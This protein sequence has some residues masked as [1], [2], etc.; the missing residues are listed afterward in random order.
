MTG[1]LDRVKSSTASALRLLPVAGDPGYPSPG[2]IAAGL[3]R[4]WRHHLG[5]M[6]RLT[7]ASA[8]MMALDP[9]TAEE[10]AESTLC[11]LRAGEPIPPFT[12][13][14]EEA[15]DWATFASPGELRAYLGAIW[16]RLPDSERD[17]FFHT[18]RPNR[19]A[20]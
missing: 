14:R 7:C 18:V 5:P 3:A 20:A 2:Y 19:R 10:L 9:D 8:A 4:I 17:S 13:L 6:E 16:N 1:R 15:R 12:T 11:D